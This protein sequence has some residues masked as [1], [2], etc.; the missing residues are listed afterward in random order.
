MPS[1]L[2]SA[3]P[4][5]TAVIAAI[6]IFFA[7]AY[8]SSYFTSRVLTPRLGL[9]DVSELAMDS[10]LLHELDSGN[11]EDARSLLIMQEDTHL[12][13]VDMLAPYF[14]DDLAKSTCHI[15]QKIAKQRAD[16]AAKYAATEATSTP[17]LRNFVAASLQNPTACSRA[18]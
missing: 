5:A 11:V 12:M 3:L 9:Q 13:T 18:Q 6:A 7:G 14:P 17:E 16:N 10:T 2:K 8:S 4:Y 1:I 15:M